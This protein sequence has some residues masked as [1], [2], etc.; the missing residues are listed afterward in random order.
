[1]NHLLRQSIYPKLKF[2]L[3]RFIGVGFLALSASGCGEETAAKVAPWLGMNTIVESKAD[4]LGNLSMKRAEGCKRRKQDAEKKWNCSYEAA[5]HA[6]SAEE[7]YLR[8]CKN[9]NNR[10]CRKLEQLRQ[11]WAIISDEAG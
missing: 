8:D 2:S 4:T 6:E 11:Y 1:M 9:G 3:R 5:A 10:A 7:L